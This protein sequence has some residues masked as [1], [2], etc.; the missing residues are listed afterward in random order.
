MIEFN[1]MPAVLES[2]ISIHY[3]VCCKVFAAD[4]QYCTKLAQAVNEDPC[5]SAYG[6]LALWRDVTL[7]Y[8]QDLPFRR[9]H[10]ESEALLESC[11]GLSNNVP[12]TYL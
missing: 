6:C 3:S 12:P 4:L 1:L 5:N 10:V 7:P 9:I 2:E 8:N 11:P